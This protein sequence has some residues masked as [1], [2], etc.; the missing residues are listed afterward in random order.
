MNP[1][2]I[3][4][5]LTYRFLS[6]VEIAP[7]G[8]HAAFI[9]KRANVEE[10]EYS[11]DIYLVDLNEL[12]A[13]RLTTSGK[14]SAFVW[15]AN[16]LDVYFVSKRVEAEDGSALFR[17]RIDG[18]EAEQIATLPHK[19][20]ALVQCD[21][22][23]VL[24]TARVPLDEQPAGEDAKEYEVLE[25]I[26]FWMNGK[27]FTSRRR[28]HL[29]R[30]DIASG[31]A[32]D[33]CEPNIEVDGVDQR[34][35]RALIIGR[36]FDGVAP[37]HHE[38]W[39]IDIATGDRHRVPITDYRLDAV[40]WLDDVTC[41]VVGSD[42]AQF[43]LNE[44]RELYAV[45]IESGSITS[46]TPGWDKS[47][48]TSIA[49]DC[50]H[51]GGPTLR[52]DEDRIYVTVTE[53]THS[54]LVR[55]RSGTSPEVVVDAL[56]SIDSYAVSGDRVLAVELRQQALQELYAYR[57][58]E[59]KAVTSLNAES[60]EGRSVSLPEPFSVRSSDGTELDAWVIRPP[61]FDSSACYPAVLTIHGGPRAA[62][63]DVFFHQMQA[64]AGHGYVIVISNP[65]GGSGRGNVFAD[66]RGKYGT[67]DYD[68][69]MAVLDEALERFSFIDRDRL[70]VMGGSYGG[71]MVNWMIGHTDRFRA[72]VSQRSIANWIHKF[73]TTDIG[74]YFNKDQMGVTPWEEG[75]SDKMWWH[76]PL[77]YAD[78]AKTPTLFIHSEQD[79]RCWLPEGIQMFTALRYHGVQSRLVMFREENHELSRSGKPKHRIRRLEEILAWFD[80]HLKG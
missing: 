36:R 12:T 13:C 6:A 40:R 25:E 26:P 16:G 77:R 51:G 33:L 5:L 42:A 37:T 11:S 79:Y 3:E 14:E 69:L 2:Q 41:V 80:K 64:M 27:G 17:I 44:N 74:Y 57:D 72:A 46:L 67:V 78:K 43:G 20:D 56:G 23:A 73:C 70:G 45:E 54:Q 19:V 59:Q 55:L 22:D 35:N 75:G 24:F 71:F 50:R 47:V 10:N 76:S 21:E 30:F 48:G 52:V 7:G 29:F 66:V 39:R 53:R 60:L 31:E 62:Y 61:G 65:H 32:M 9:V 18:G 49:G 34:G 63:S 8:R 1:V 15:G 4:D 28:L 38:L 68:D 58:E